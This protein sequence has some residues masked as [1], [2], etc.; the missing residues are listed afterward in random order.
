MPLR[1]AR[2]MRYGSPTIAPRRPY[3]R[4]S[5]SS[6]WQPRSGSQRGRGVGD[7]DAAGRG[8]GSVV[9]GNTSERFQEECAD[10][11]RPGRTSKRMLRMALSGLLVV[12]VATSVVVTVVRAPTTVSPLAQHAHRQV[13]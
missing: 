2:E 12:L 4:P 11:P 8:A 10:A 1:C 9:D 7:R 3:I 6:P 13:P 5:G